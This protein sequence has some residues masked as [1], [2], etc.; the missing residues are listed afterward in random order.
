M[1]RRHGSHFDRNP[2][3][4]FDMPKHARRPLFFRHAVVLLLLC[5]LL[6]AAFPLFA[7]QAS[8]SGGDSSSRPVPLEWFLDETGAR[9][10]NAIL[11]PESAQLFEP[12]PDGGFPNEAGTVWLRFALPPDQTGTPCLDLNERLAGQLPDG[13]E[14]WVVRRPSNKA[15]GALPEALDALVSGLYLLPKVSESGTMIY[16]RVPGVPSPG[17]APAIRDRDDIS[18]LGLDGLFW[19]QIVLGLLLTLCLVRG[20][21]ERREWRL[22]SGLYLVAALVSLA[23]GVPGTPG[24]LPDPQSLPG[25]LAPGVALL[26]LPHAGRQMM[27]TQDV[28][29]NLDLALIS[30]GIG[31]LLLA[32]TP[33]VPHAEGFVRLL[34][35]W[36]LGMLLCWPIAF[37]ALL[38]KVP[39]SRVFALAVLLP[40]LGFLP[41]WFDIPGSP[42]FIKLL[43]FLTACLSA[44]GLALLPSPRHLPRA[45]QRRASV[46]A[47][48]DEGA[49]SPAL[50]I[51][52][53]SAPRAGAPASDPLTERLNALNKELNTLFEHP[54]QPALRMRVRLLADALTNGMRAASGT[55]QPTSFSLHEVILEAHNTVSA[56]AERQNLA[57]TWY[58]APQLSRQYVGD[59]TALTRT[60]TELLASSIRATERG[61]VQLRAQRLPE[62]NDPGLLMFTIADTG[63][64]TSPDKRD[65]AALLHAWELAGRLGGS[66]GLTSGPTGTTVTVVLR[67][68]P[69]AETAPLPETEQQPELKA[70]LS[71]ALRVLIVS[72]VPASRQ[73]L[74]YY[75]DELP[76]ELR[77][78]RS[79][80]EALTMYAQAPGALI[81]LDGDLPE[82]DLVR[83]IAQLRA[84]E[85]EH[86]LPPA[87]I[88]GLTGTEAQAEQLRR[89]GCTHTL[90]RPVQRTELRHMVLRLAPLPRQRNAAP[91]PRT[92]K[93][94]PDGRRK[95][96]ATSITVDPAAEN[97]E[98]RL[99]PEQD[100]LNKE[101]AASQNDTPQPDAPDAAPAAA[102]AADSAPLRF[103]QPPT[104]SVRSNV[105]EPMPVSKPA[106]AGNATAD[107]EEDSLPNAALAAG[108]TGSAT[109]EDAPASSARPDGGN[110]SVPPIR[111]VRIQAVSRVPAADSSAA[112]PRSMRAVP[113]QP[114]SATS[115]LSPWTGGSGDWVGDPVPIGTPAAT[116]NAPTTGET[117]GATPAGSPDAPSETATRKAVPQA[118]SAPA[119]TPPVQTTAARTTAVQTT[120]AQ[121]AAEPLPSAP[122]PR[123]SLAGRAAPAADAASP[124]ASLTP[125]QE[126]TLPAFAAGTKKKQGFV[127]RLTGLFSG[128]KTPPAAENALSQQ[129]VAVHNPSEWV[130]EPMPLLKA[131][132]VLPDA[133]PLQDGQNGRNCQNSRIAD[134]SGSDGAAPRAAAGADTPDAAFAAP[135]DLTA[136]LPAP[137]PEPQPEPLTLTEPLTLAAPLDEPLTLTEPLPAPQ[138]ETADSAASRNAAPLQNGQDGR[139][140]QNSRIADGSGSDGAAPRAAAGA[141]APDAAF[142]APIDLTEPLPEPQPEPLILTEPLPTPLPEL[143]PAGNGLTDRIMP[144]P[145]EPGPQ[146]RLS[147]AD[148]GPQ[149]AGDVAGAA[150]IEL[151]DP[152]GQSTAPAALPELFPSGSGAPGAVLTLSAPP[153]HDHAMPQGTGTL[154]GGQPTPGAEKTPAG[155][156][157]SL[158]TP[159]DSGM[160]SL[161]LVEPQSS[162]PRDQEK[163]DDALELTDRVAPD[164]PE[165]R[166]EPVTSTHSTPPAW[167]PDAAADSADHLP[168]CGERRSSG[169]SNPAAPGGSGLS[170][171]PDA[172]PLAGTPQAADATAG[173]PDGSAPADTAK[174]NPAGGKDMAACDPADDLDVTALLNTLSALENALREAAL[175]NDLPA[176]RGVSNTM[177]NTADALRMPTL[178]DMARCLAESDDEN[179][180]SLLEATLEAVHQACQ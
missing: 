86:A 3:P 60:L 107:T 108:A 104:L 101:R 168:P 16:L 9:T 26:L 34:A 43:P 1:A 129:D 42:D 131:D 116:Q 48:P 17:F 136:P 11:T 58:V 47:Q 147:G 10:L 166:L 95:L 24:G 41:L 37:A 177:A 50:V 155:A 128:K 69:A 105:G 40:P 49:P 139:N 143:F 127:A 18:S 84:F 67:L 62:S 76:H 53:L 61:S 165:L 52:D 161:T 149:P 169:S 30:V 87:A 175:R 124:A 130:G 51:Q 74:A 120:A 65:P 93:P 151:T 117:A 29:P 125:G 13:V 64:G 12:V 148:T 159:Q 162:L 59:R 92:E 70:A 20:V 123:Q 111:P 35:L 156:P 63:S 75:L 21:T 31:G 68:Q 118:G 91:R 178:A 88:L 94:R 150:P 173:S 78:A 122:A 38:R 6:A 55:A 114:G 152:V 110:V 71:S 80:G 154:P 138:A 103:L 157:L 142:A 112:K 160:P 19:P 33:L 81:I 134:G 121:A 172:P 28:M 176:L 23:W 25:L 158:G 140:C 126:D 102:S 119:Q 32:L 46:P 99:L 106:G 77:E 90:C 174:A 179:R 27:Q 132:P 144:L 73:L 163:T 36:P 72:G 2:D 167:S 164:M 22:L 137:Q 8:T 135:I 133:A 170:A 79:T 83:F 171:A 98:W 89:A 54:L 45:V 66:L 115:G 145:H 14:V 39:G 4:P 57:L 82:D 146:R 96:S 5:G 44:L 7:E 109:A 56:T 85:G 97:S 15:T 113:Y 141:D 180:E 100:V 153:D